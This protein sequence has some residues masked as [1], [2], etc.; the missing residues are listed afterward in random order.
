[1]RIIHVMRHGV[2]V[3]ASL[4][5]RSNRNWEDDSGRFEKWL[6][7]Y[8]WRRSQLPIRRGQRAATLENA[9]DFWAEQVSIENSIIGQREEVLRIRFEDILSQPEMKIS[10][11][12]DFAGSSINPDMLE[13]MTSSLDP[14][15]AFSHREDSELSKFAKQNSELL[16]DF[17]Y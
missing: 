8:R 6:P 7:I 12:A 10:E 2:D 13:E 3:A 4:H 16:A 17:G 14:S 9:L 1:M 5:T 11:I 15:R